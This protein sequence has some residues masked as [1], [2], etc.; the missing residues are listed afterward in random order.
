[1]PQIGTQMLVSLVLSDEGEIEGWCGTLKKVQPLLDELSDA[2]LQG[3]D[4]RF[5]NGVNCQEK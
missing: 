1:M 4:Y 5:G 3:S 2:A